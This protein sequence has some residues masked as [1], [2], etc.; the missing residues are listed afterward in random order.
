MCK[1]RFS[2]DKGRGKEM[3][4]DKELAKEHFVS[5]MSRG[6][7][8]M[9][10]GE[11]NMWRG[12]GNMQRTTC[13]ML[14]PFMQCKALWGMP[15]LYVNLSSREE[16]STLPASCLDGLKRTSCFPVDNCG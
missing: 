7:G 1:H 13:S 2:S 16:A 14:L 12:E 4:M 15:F 3:L 8:N 11:G 6:E 9:W 10:R 5:C